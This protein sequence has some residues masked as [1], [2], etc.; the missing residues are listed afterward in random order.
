MISEQAVTLGVEPGVTLEARTAVPDGAR[1]G[2]AICHPHPLYGGDMDNPV[3]VRAAEVGAEAGLAT[4]RFNFRG[5]GRSTGTHGGGDAERRDLAAALTH[6]GAVLPADSTL[7]AAGYS[8]G[9]MV[10]AHVAA[11]GGASALALIAPPLGLDAFRRLPELP[12]RLP[13]FIGVGSADEYC[14]P[15]AIDRLR[16]ALP[17]AAITVVE[18]ANHFFFGKLHPLGAAL[19]GWLR[20]TV[21]SLDAR[22]TRGRGGAG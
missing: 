3:V 12:A 10:A 2:I 18:G 15:E 4:I 17:Q 21:A 11:A 14:P 5:V 13:L 1:T 9:A 20:A 8:F 7:I 19:D 22:Q 16:E 6:L